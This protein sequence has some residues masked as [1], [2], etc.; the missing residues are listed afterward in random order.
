MNVIA[1]HLNDNTLKVTWTS[2]ET[3]IDLFYAYTD[4]IDKKHCE[5][6]KDQQ[7]CI[8]TELQSFTFYTVCIQACRF[9]PISTESPSTNGSTTEA[10]SAYP[11][12]LLCSEP[13]CVGVNTRPSGKYRF[14]NDTLR[15]LLQYSLR[16][17]CH[18]HFDFF[19]IFSRITSAS[20]MAIPLP[21]SPFHW[22]IYI[23]YCATL[24]L[25]PWTSHP[26][27]T[28]ISSD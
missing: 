1:T 21:L 20:L 6:T 15:W 9:L 10:S 4:G 3:G 18:G 8:I 13:E 14:F 12:N 19:C 7:F 24:I 27:S 25:I 16:F 23:K 17:L 2:N 11:D 22:H 28:G 5:S 26:F